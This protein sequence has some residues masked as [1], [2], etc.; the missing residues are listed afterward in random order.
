M[1]KAAKFPSPA[2]ESQQCFKSFAHTREREANIFGRFRLSS[3]APSLRHADSLSSENKR[4]R[5]PVCDSRRSV[6]AIRMFFFGNVELFAH[7]KR[8]LAFIRNIPR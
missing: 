5:T 3:P 1:L 6:R 8:S 7:Q 4:N 2:T